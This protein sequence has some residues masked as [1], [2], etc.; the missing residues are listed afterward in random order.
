[1]ALKSSVLLHAD[2]Q[3]EGS[4]CKAKGKRKALLSKGPMF[5]AKAYH[6]VGDREPGS[7]QSISHSEK[8]SIA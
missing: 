6:S 3:E 1:M 8:C 4:R 7:M 2:M 5:T